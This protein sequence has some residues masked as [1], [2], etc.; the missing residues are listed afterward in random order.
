M[1]SIREYKSTLQAWDALSTEC[2]SSYKSECFAVQDRK[3]SF[4]FY[5]F[6]IFV[7][8]I[9]HTNPKYAIAL[10]PTTWNMFR[11]KIM[12]PRA[13]EQYGQVSNS[14]GEQLLVS[15]SIRGYQ[16]YEEVIFFKEALCGKWNTS[17]PQ[18]WHFAVT[19]HVD[20]FAPICQGKSI[21]EPLVMRNWVSN[22]STF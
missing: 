9:C 8:S 2:N 20:I 10:H 5:W 7:T 19:Y 14:R 1:L 16:G 13:S 6:L 11:I 4:H 3:R 15:A 21:S 12:Y 17:V 18:G 22:S